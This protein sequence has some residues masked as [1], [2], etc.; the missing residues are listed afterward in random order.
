M[1]AGFGSAAVTAA[2]DRSLDALVA[3]A[4]GTASGGGSPVAGVLSASLDSLGLSA[5][6]RVGTGGYVV[7]REV[8]GQRR[9]V[10]L[11]LG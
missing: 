6:G 11:A 4:S 5:C 10:V 1:G 2:L 8:S 3:A 9:A 7:L